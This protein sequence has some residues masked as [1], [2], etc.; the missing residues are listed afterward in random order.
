[1][2]ES[3]YV[4]LVLVLAVAAILMIKIRK[5]CQDKNSVIW[6]PSNKRLVTAISFEFPLW[7]SR[8]N[9]RKGCWVPGRISDAIL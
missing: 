7:R 4:Y 6:S 9:L 8:A 2:N 5:S 1:M 3:I